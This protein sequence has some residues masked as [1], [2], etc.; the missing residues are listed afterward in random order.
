MMD[1]EV[2]I[3]L[4]KENEMPELTAFQGRVNIKKNGKL[5]VKNSVLENIDTFSEKELRYIFTNLKKY[6]SPIVTSV[7]IPSP[8]AM[9]IL[10]ELAPEFK[11]R[12]KTEKP[13]T[14]SMVPISSKEFF[15]GEKI[16]DE[17]LAGMKK[18]WSEEQKY[19]YLYNKIGQMLSYDLNVL[20]HDEYGIFHDKYGRNI[21]T[22][23]AKNWGSCASFAASYDY[24]CY[25][26][27]LESNILSEEDHDYVAITTEEQED[28]L[29]DPTF[30]SVAA[31]FGLRMQ[32]F[33]ISEKEFL[34]NGHHLEDT[35]IEGYQFESMDKDTVKEL[36]RTTGYLEEF[37][38]DYTDEYLIEC[39]NT[40]QGKDNFQK[41]EDFLQKVQ[42]LKTVGRPTSYDF[43][44]VI[45][46][47]LS[48]CKDKEFA[49]GMNAYTVVCEDAS[50]LPR[51]LVIE[52]QQE[53]VLEKKQYYV[54]E[55]LRTFEKVDK[56]EVL[57]NL[58]ER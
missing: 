34:K 33:A 42:K 12:F 50:D 18:E 8:I 1:N 38:G 31:K 11:V 26:A 7:Y 44:E 48:K 16:F 49:K 41:A 45:K 25:K 5:I 17:I 27:G 46:W 20:T 9:K 36:D 22:A 43:E 53:S 14:K 56:I 39:V 15:E 52:V 10:E 6:I 57:E 58:K 28:Y 32:N 24:M 47:M 30:D 54:F 13:G 4:D 37:G 55:N 2:F 21:F 40:L 29:T 19:K 35:E 3:D 23:I 51:K